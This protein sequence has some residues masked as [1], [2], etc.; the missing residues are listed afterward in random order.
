MHALMYLIIKPELHTVIDPFDGFDY[1]FRR[2]SLGK[3]QSRITPPHRAPLTVPCSDTQLAF[4]F[5]ILQPDETRCQNSPAYMSGSDLNR[6][7]D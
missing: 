4:E 3:L 6:Q 2:F 5:P 7:V 1:E